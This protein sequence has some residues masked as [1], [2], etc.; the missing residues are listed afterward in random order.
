MNVWLV[1]VTERSD[2]GHYCGPSRE[3]A[4][5]FTSK[6]VAE[7]YVRLRTAASPILGDRYSIESREVRDAVAENDREWMTRMAA[8]Q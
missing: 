8:Q 5:I 6:P 1:I 2:C 7:E 3:I 4:D